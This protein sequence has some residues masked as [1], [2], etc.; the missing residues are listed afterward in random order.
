MGT[1]AGV[2]GAVAGGATGMLARCVQSEGATGAVCRCD[3]CTAGVMGATGA[4]CFCDGRGLLTV[5]G[6]TDAMPGWEA[7]LLCSWRT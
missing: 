5:A 6:A 1:S 7:Y 4:V 3:G 2:I